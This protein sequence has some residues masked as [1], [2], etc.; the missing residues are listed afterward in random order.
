VNNRLNGSY[1]FGTKNSKGMKA[2][3]DSSLTLYIQHD[4]PGKYKEAN[5]LPAPKSEFET[6]IRTY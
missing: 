3:A 2:N 5:W 1:S 4:S 6:T